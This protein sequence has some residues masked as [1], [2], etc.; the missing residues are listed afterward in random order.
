MFP[1]VPTVHAGKEEIQ[2]LYILGYDAQS[3]DTNIPLQTVN[4]IF[5]PMH[6]AIKMLNELQ[7]HRIH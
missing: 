3:T 6:Y 1:P 7:K 4:P 2:N 5:R